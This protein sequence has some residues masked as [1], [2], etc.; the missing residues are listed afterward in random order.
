V[1]SFFFGLCSR[2]MICFGFIF[3]VNGVSDPNYKASFP[4]LNSGVCWGYVLAHISRPPP[5]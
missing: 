1:L 5:V 4:F 2:L 3:V